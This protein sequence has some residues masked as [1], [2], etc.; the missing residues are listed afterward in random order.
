MKKKIAITVVICLFVSVLSIRAQMRVH[1]I[2]VGQGCATLIEFPCAAILVDAGG[3]NNQFCSSSDS[4]KAYLDDFFARRQD[5]R[6]TLQCLYLTH[7]HADHTRG[8]AL[9]L[10]PPFV[11]K[12]AVTD[13]LPASSSS[14]QAKLH[15]AVQDA[16]ENGNAGDDI[17]FQPVN[18]N[19]LGT[20]GL[21]NDIIDPVVCPGSTNPVIRVLWGTTPVNPG[22]PLTKFQNP[23]N[24]SLVLKI[25]YGTSSVLITG[26]LEEDAQRAMLTKYRTSAI[27]HA[28]VYVAGH[29]GS[30]NG[31]LPELLRKIKPK[32]V[33]I[34]VGDPNH[35]TPMSAFDYGHPNKKNLDSMQKRITTARP[36]I[37]VK[38]GKAE[39]SF[40]SNYLVSKAVYATAWDGNIVLEADNAG[41]WRKVEVLDMPVPDQ[42]NINTA[43]LS[44]LLTLPGIGETRA[45]AILK[46][47]ND[48]GNFTSIEQLDNVEGIG[49]ATIKLIRPF[50]R[51]SD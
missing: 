27:L 2:N 9:L 41:N 45:K 40:V 35:H 32:I 4:L 39:E 24:H 20:S 10:D 21:T 49:P 23:N 44:D 43:T 33:L 30:G 15:E 48:N 13:G 47:R 36:P 28:D 1:L 51:L 8:V 26:D 17:G 7:P 29:H 11:I 3:E 19:L 42:I 12:N 50:V 31:T 34:G 22:W 46:Y 5:L 18:V 37:H 6:H 38:V 16:E 25:E 14:G